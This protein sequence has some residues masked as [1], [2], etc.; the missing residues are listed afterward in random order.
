[1]GLIHGYTHISYYRNAPVSP[2]FDILGAFYT[3]GIP[4]YTYAI[5]TAVWGKYGVVSNDVE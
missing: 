2:Y 5:K 3:V 1:M 4:Y